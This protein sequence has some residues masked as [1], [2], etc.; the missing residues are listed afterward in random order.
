MPYT[1]TFSRLSVLVTLALA[2]SALSHRA[3]AATACVWRVTNAPAP[4]YLVG[5]LHALASS[6]YPLPEAYYQ[7]LHESKRLIFELKPDPKSNYP[8]KFA[9]AATYPKGDYIQRHIHPKTW[10]I[11]SRAYRGSSYFGKAFTM[12]DYYIDSIEKLRP[13]A[14][15][16]FIWGI[17]GY[18]DVYDQYGVDNYL[19]YQAKRF[20]KEVA[21]IE[22]DDEHVAVLADFSDIDSELTLVEAIARGDKRRDDYNAARDAWKR[23]DI[24]ALRAVDQRSR[25]L[26]PGADVRLLDERNVRWIPR[27][28]AE[29]KTGV[30]TSLVVGAGHFM[31]PNG[32][33]ELL[34]RGGYTI[35][36]L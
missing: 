9:A 33:V 16:Y 13:W 23:G 3:N 5:T 26:N 30:P 8:R 34:K 7:A 25:N 24:N 10:A 15:A 36:Q 27:I 32:V 31:G 12:G 17:R 22:S 6:D 14:V 29:M 21:G 1:R 20:H 11:L 19:A 35:E 18:N 4:F 2:G 28:K